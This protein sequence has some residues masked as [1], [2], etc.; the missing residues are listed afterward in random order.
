VE[1]VPAFGLGRRDLHDR[2]L[3]FKTAAK[4]SKRIDVLLTGGIDRYMEARFETS[5]IVRVAT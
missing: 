1:R 4:I 2:R 3:V 5:V